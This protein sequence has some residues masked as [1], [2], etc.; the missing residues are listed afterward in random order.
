MVAV[1]L[2]PTLAGAERYTS[3]M[4]S[5]RRTAFVRS[6]TASFEKMLDT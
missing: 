1:P 5:A 6:V 2:A 4:P 3:P